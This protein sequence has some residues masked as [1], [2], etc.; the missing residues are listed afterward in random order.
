MKRLLISLS[1]RFKAIIPKKRR[2][3]EYSSKTQEKSSGAV[4]I[5]NPAEMGYSK[6]RSNLSV[7]LMRKQTNQIQRRNQYAAEMAA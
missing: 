5:D 7:L 4:F 1:V 3:C 2:G 6:G